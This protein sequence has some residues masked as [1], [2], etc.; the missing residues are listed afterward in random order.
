MGLLY[1]G[2]VY[3]WEIELGKVWH[4]LSV[5]TPQGRRPVEKARSTVR[6]MNE[7]IGY[8]EG[9][10]GSGAEGVTGGGTRMGGGRG[11]VRVQGTGGETGQAGDSGR[12]LW[13]KIGSKK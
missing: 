7:R 4:F 11:G 5:P 10:E 9:S 3:R 2:T 1:I 12:P 8:T 13:K 6:D